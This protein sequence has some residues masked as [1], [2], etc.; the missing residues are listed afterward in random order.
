MRLLGV[1][2]MAEVIKCDRTN[3]VNVFLKR[4]TK[5]MG[6]EGET[7]TPDLGGMAVAP[8]PVAM[9]HKNGYIWYHEY[10]SNL[11]KNLVKADD[12]FNVIDRIDIDAVI[13]TGDI[14]LSSTMPLNDTACFCSA[15]LSDVP[16]VFLANESGNITKIGSETKGAGVDDWDCPNSQIDVSADGQLYACDSF[17]K[18]VKVYDYG[19][20]ANKV[21]AANAQIITQIYYNNAVRFY[22]VDNSGANKILTWYNKDLTL[23]S[24]LVIGTNNITACKA[25][26]EGNEYFALI[27]DSTNTTFKINLSDNTVTNIFIGKALL[28]SQLATD[29]SKIYTLESGVINIYTMAGVLENQ[30]TN[31]YGYTFFK[32]K[33]YNNK[34]YAIDRKGIDDCDLVSFDLNGDNKSIVISDTYNLLYAVDENEFAYFLDFTSQEIKKITQNEN[35]SYSFSESGSGDGQLNCGNTSDILYCGELNKFLISDTSNNR[36]QTFNF[37]K[38]VD[39]TSITS[40]NYIHGIVFIPNS[41]FFYIHD[42]TRI[43]KFTTNGFNLLDAETTATYFSDHGWLYY[44]SFENAIYA[45]MVLD[46]KMIKMSL[47]DFKINW[48]LFNKKTEL[49]I[50]GFP[51]IVGEKLYISFYQT[52][53]A[54]G[55]FTGEI[56][57]F[58]IS[59]NFDT[60]WI[61]I[62]QSVLNKNINIK[63][64]S[65]ES[66]FSIGKLTFGTLNLE[67][68]NY[69]GKFDFE[70][71]ENSIFYDTN[72]NLQRNGSMIKIEVSGN[73]I[74]RFL[75]DG[76]NIKTEENKLSLTLFDPLKYFETIDINYIL[77]VATSLNVM[78][79]L[80]N[81]RFF[82]EILEYN[83]SD[84]DAYETDYGSMF[85]FTSDNCFDLLK[86]L[87]QVGK[88]RFGLYNGNKFFAKE[89]ITKLQNKELD[90]L[91]TENNLI[92]IISFNSGE[93]RLFKTVTVEYKLN[94]TDDATATLELPKSVQL[95]FNESRSV[96]FKLDGITAQADAETVANDFVYYNIFPTKEIEVKIP[97]LNYG[98]NIFDKTFAFVI[99]ENKR[100]IN[101]NKPALETNNT[102]LPDKETAVNSGKIV[103]FV[104][105]LSHTLLNE[106]TTILKLKEFIAD[107]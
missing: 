39:S 19:V 104:N 32:I 76:K 57:S 48:F 10:G 15:F 68:S 87:S 17:N 40:S 86:K 73:E 37:G 75:I 66:G 6:L 16:H 45:K 43:V 80:I 46:V 21:T 83:V 70:T 22:V 50:N 36:L 8:V 12:E 5:N 54:P 4:K 11:S 62:T 35:F 1:N 89:Y 61:N 27:T 20:F 103:Y 25:F 105:G 44:S 33:L 81:N 28:Q 91:I 85:N 55:D 79:V 65:E 99:F 78:E 30:I 14:K 97:F 51:L 101:F 3:D 38:L 49:Y 95:L 90:Y 74:A 58:E 82:E 59:P 72:G 106:Y 26:M 102:I 84:I 29:G 69:Y 88:F 9:S 24:S 63:Y 13:G 94:G 98:E 52:T 92:D 2:I 93:Q 71:N 67:L 96:E 34:L 56:V 53:A 41:E 47:S 107:K 18:R 23:I 31:T 60:E 77:N 7:I 100:G 64:T 42:E